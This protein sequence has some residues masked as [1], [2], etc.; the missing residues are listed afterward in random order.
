MRTVAHDA[1]CVPWATVSC[2]AVV[3]VPGAPR[4]NGLIRRRA[5]V[6][7]PRAVAGRGVRGIG[8]G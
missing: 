7:K 1:G 2:G 6:P 3:C 4:V 5:D 8:G